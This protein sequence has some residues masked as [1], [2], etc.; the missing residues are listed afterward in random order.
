MLNLRRHR[1]NKFPAIF[2]VLL[3][4]ENT[5]R[6]TFDFLTRI[7]LTVAHPTVISKLRQLGHD[8]QL[9]IRERGAE[10]QFHPPDFRVLFDNVNKTEHVWRQVLGQKDQVHC[11]TTAII[12]GL[13]DVPEGGLDLDRYIANINLKRR[14]ELTVDVLLADINW[15]HLRSVGAGLLLRIWIKYVPS[16]KHFHANVEALFKTDLAVHRLPTR[17]S[18]IETLECSGINEATTAGAG[19]VARNI[20]YDQL[21]IDPNWLENYILMLQGDQL[22]TDRLRK[23][24]A[25]KAKGETNAQRFSWS[26][27]VVQL[28]HLRWNF[29]KA[30]MRLNWCTETG[31]DT[32]G[33]YHDLQLLG[34]EKFNHQKCD[35]YPAHHILTDRFEALALEAL[36]YHYFITLFEM[37]I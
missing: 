1:V 34:R 3:F 35:Y 5:P 28:W 21:G 18:R 17:K 13:E 19:A 36:R 14:A 30:I 7:G 23:H 6:D 22:S 11:G 2:G 9:R 16:L 27:E 33:L 24:R 10:V 26:L 15:D 4:T 32:F 29:Q 8:S 12:I 31:K 20:V 37:P 25:Y